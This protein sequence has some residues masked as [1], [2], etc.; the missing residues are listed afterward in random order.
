[1]KNKMRKN[2]GVL[3]LLFGAIMTTTQTLAAEFSALNAQAATGPAT[4][5]LSGPT[6][7]SGNEQS[8]L[9]QEP[10]V[11]SMSSAKAMILAV[12]HAGNRIVAVGDRGI[13]RISDDGVVFR[14]A[15]SVPSQAT[16]TSVSFVNDKEGWVAGHWGVVLHTVDGGETWALQHENVKEDL[17]YFSIMF[18]NKEHGFVVGLWS[19][20]LETHDGGVTWESIKI[21]PP[22]GSTKADRNLLCLFA[23]PK[24][25]LLIAAEGG[26]VY[27]STDNG[28]S[29]IPVETGN[30][31]SF[32]TGAALTNGDLLVAGLAGNMF[33]SKDDGKTWQRVETGVRSSITEIVSFPDGKVE[34]VG[35]DGL[36]LTSNDSGLT[37][38]AFQREDRLDITA[39]TIN[40]KSQLILFSREGVASK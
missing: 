23:S 3:A 25:A 32:W 26:I 15:K 10:A 7:A 2:V 14:Q 22:K 27:R 1:M 20:M 11:I 31:G 6:M 40:Q 17:P 35:L 39:A 9:K 21:P 13:I 5:E 18:L 36:T 38:T 34:A 37:F 29:W 30:R 4:T 8:N 33:R 19:T 16:L 28:E 12:T 24:G